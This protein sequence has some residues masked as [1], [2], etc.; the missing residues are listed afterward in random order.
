VPIKELQQRLT[1][2]GV[3]R[4]GEQRM[5]KNN[6]PYPAKLDTFRVTSP[7]KDLVEAVAALYGGQ[8]TAWP[9]GPGGGQW[10]VVT[11][12]TEIPVHVLPQK[13]DPNYELWGNGFRSRLC[14]GET[15]RIR[16]CPCFCAAD[17]AEAE[18]NGGTWVRDARRHCKP[19]TRVS[20]MLSD[21]PSLGTWKIES[22]GWN[23]A[24]ELPTLAMALLNQVHQPVPA[25]LRM[26]QREDRVLNVSG[27]EEKVEPRKYAVPVLD[28]GQ[29]ATPRQALGGGMD[30]VLHNAVG[31]GPDRQAISAAPAAA[32]EQN[33]PRQQGLAVDWRAEV[34]A[35]K[36]P[37]ALNRLQERMKNAGVADQSLVEAW[38]ARK[39]EIEG[40]AGQ[41]A[42]RQPAPQAEAEAV[43]AEVEPDMDATWSKILKAGDERRWNLPAIEERYRSHMGHDPADED[44][45]NGFK[46]AVFLAAVEDGLVQ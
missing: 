13:I 22:H 35:V 12:T 8:V 4:L 11:K 39:A 23:A 7:S 9:E 32:V 33:P 44:V 42:G 46:Y 41:S 20:V 15:E 38:M 26:E 24:A 1:Q 28:F 31:A 16:N 10:Q 40:T 2:V 27:A 21:I 17:R 18:A 14:D 5:S 30:A 19:T 45:A 36:T 6:K 29:L 34:A 43:D 25:I 37:A 3:I